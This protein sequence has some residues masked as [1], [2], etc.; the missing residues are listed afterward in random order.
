MHSKRSAYWASIILALPLFDA[1]VT[2]DVA[3]VERCWVNEDL[4]NIK[5]VT[6]REQGTML[7]ISMIIECLL[8]FSL[9]SGEN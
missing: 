4:V 9:N 2:E 1:E 5:N 8:G 3:A 7:E 6:Y